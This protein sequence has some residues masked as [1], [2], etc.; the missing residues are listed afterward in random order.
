MPQQY[1]REMLTSKNILLVYPEF[2]RRSFWGMQYSMPVAGKKASFPPLGLITIA[3]MSPPEFAFRL[4]D[5]NCRGL[6]DEAIEWADLVCF[7]AMLPQKSTLF[8]AASRCR[9]AGK[10]VVFG[11]PYPTACPG[12]CGP[13]CDTLV[14]N[15][16]EVTWKAF[17]ADLQ[18]GQLRSV[19]ET[20]THPDLGETPVPR[21]DLLDVDDYAMIPVQFS[22]GCPY[23]CEFCDIIALFGRR[24][25]TKTPAQI[26]AELEA[27]FRAGYRGGV[28]FA[29]DNFIGNRKEVR[30]LLPAIR[31]WNESK[32]H[33]FFYLTQSSLDLA[34][35]GGLLQDLVEADFK[36]VFLGIE[37]PSR[38]SLQETGKHQ[39]LRGDLVEAVRTIQSAGMVVHGGFVIGFDHDGEDI[40]ERQADFIERAAIPNAL[41]G[42]L[43]ALPGAALHER[44]SR[45]GRLEPFDYGEWGESTTNIRTRIP[46]RQ[47]LE[48]YRDLMKRIYTPEAYFRRVLETFSRLP[49]PD[50]LA[51]RARHLSRV[52]SQIVRLFS[53][54]RQGTRGAGVSWRA[55]AKGLGDFFGQM[56]PGYRR[57][58]LKF[59]RAF[60]RQCPERLPGALLFILM[61]VHLYQYTFLDLIP[62][63]DRRLDEM[64]DGE[65]P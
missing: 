19:Y 54:R 28:F 12:E 62:D 4:V 58:S 41:V 1:L 29:D 7:S 18:R 44:L 13:H 32:G 60:L 20:R 45:E 55:R 39:N 31:T 26:L 50:T 56:P 14:L 34:A 33:P 6:T 30:S 9:A 5:M 65:A 16:G 53:E 38:E 64:T 51:G 22:R 3:A 52:G 40:F 2:P 48:G 59:L 47:L 17:L 11:G 42:F 49:R 25:R 8:R 35:E 23:N 43:F 57:E 46:R 21:F 15:E 37:T 10:H 63:L 24:P 61:G 36:G 27:I